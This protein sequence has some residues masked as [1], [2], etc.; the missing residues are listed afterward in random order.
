MN[1]FYNIFLR[2]SFSLKCW[3][4]SVRG[5]IPDFFF[6]CFLVD[7]I[8]RWV[9]LILNIIIIIHRRHHHHHIYIYSTLHRI[10]LLKPRGW[11]KEL[12]VFFCCVHERTK[13]K[14]FFFHMNTWTGHNGHRFLFLRGW[15]W[16]VLSGVWLKMDFRIIE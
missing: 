13:K 16:W 2:F 3:T 6:F 15:C 7:I 12:V 9:W 4:F 8:W 14:W 5:T 10:I 11:I 1:G